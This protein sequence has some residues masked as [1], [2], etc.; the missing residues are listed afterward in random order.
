MTT[1]NIDK[2]YIESPELFPRN[3][4]VT[5]DGNRRWSKSKGLH[6]TEGHRVSLENLRGII[7]RA[8]E[9][10]IKTITFWVFSHEN[11]SRE[12][13]F[14]DS[15]FKLAR[16][17]LNKKK[18]FEDITKM[19][20]K[21]GV[22]GDL[23]LFPKD[24]GQKMRELVSKSNPVE[25]KIAVN[26][27]LGYGGRDEMVRAFKRMVSDKVS[28][29]EVTEEKIYTYLD[30]QEDI[31]LMIRTGARKRTS[32]LYIYQAAY[33]ELYFTD[34]LCPDFTVEEFDKAI[35]D[36]TTRQRNFGR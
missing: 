11:F 5:L 25:Q 17:Y 1:P 27:A 34:I 3:V 35:F 12:K 33:A 22:I 14:L 9:L 20:G 15:A 24:I 19:G 4:A 16:E 29:E 26:F 32:G 28:P 18:Y 8:G 36:F 31:D 2:L 23:S 21:L 7:T 30:M 6:E 10:G 13:S